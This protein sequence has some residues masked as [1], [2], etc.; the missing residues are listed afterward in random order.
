MYHLWSN[1]TS[2]YVPWNDGDPGMWFLLR[3]VEEPTPRQVQTCGVKMILTKSF[4]LQN[5]FNKSWFFGPSLLYNYICFCFG[6]QTLGW[7][8]ASE[9][10]ACNCR[11]SKVKKVLE[12]TWW[13]RRRQSFQHWRH[14]LRLELLCD[15]RNK[16]KADKNARQPATGTKIARRLSWKHVSWVSLVWF[17]S[18]RKV[19]R[20]KKRQGQAFEI[21]KHGWTT[22]LWAWKAPLVADAADAPVPPVDDTIAAEVPSAESLAHCPRIGRTCDSQLRFSW[23]S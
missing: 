17:L 16:K 12:E 7:H 21:C 22:L 8:H 2:K 3:E 15:G 20:Q 5:H 10:F 4:F 13:R 9:I 6:G 23:R 11:L 1:W 19:H 14:E 18:R